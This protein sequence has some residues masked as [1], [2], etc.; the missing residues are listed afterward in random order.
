MHLPMLAPTTML[1]FT[2]DPI[3]PSSKGCDEE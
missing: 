2:W 3:P 1:P